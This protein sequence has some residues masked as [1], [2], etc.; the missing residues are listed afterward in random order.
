MPP[1]TRTQTKS[2]P[3]R[4][5]DTSPIAKTP[6]SRPLR[7]R[8]TATHP[9]NA[10]NTSTTDSTNSRG[11]HSQSPPRFTIDLSLPP[12]E[13]YAEV[14]HAL[15]DEMRG[16][17]SLF[18]EVVGGLLPSWIPV[19]SVLLN[20]AAWAFWWRV[21]DAEEDAELDVSF[22]TSLHYPST[23]PSRSLRYRWYGRMG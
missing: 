3:A 13:R 22:L 7:H 18:D 10:K 16:L 23:S 14:C 12:S 17:Q 8:K 9:S 19:P 20:W 6:L 1:V 15:G 21:C 5:D 2:L 11:N 4:K